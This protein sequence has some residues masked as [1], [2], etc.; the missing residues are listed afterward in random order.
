MTG[1]TGTTEAW[2]YGLDTD[3]DG[4]TVTVDLTGCR[5]TDQTTYSPMDRLSR[6]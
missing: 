3:L 4:V 5:D 1:A 2:I 6:R